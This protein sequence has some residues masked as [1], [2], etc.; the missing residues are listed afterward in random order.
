MAKNEVVKNFYANSTWTAPAGVKFVVVTTKKYPRNLF[1]GGFIDPFG[2]A[3]ACGLN[4]NGQLGLGDVT[5][6]SSPVAVLGGFA[7]KKVINMPTGS[8]T[9]GMSTSGNLYAWGLN[10]SGQL[11]VGDVTPRSSPVAVLGSLSFI[12]VIVPQYNNG[13]DVFGLTQSGALYAWGSNTKGQLGLGDTTVRSSPVAVVGGFTFGYFAAIDANGN[14]SCYG[15]TKAGVAYAWGNNANGQLGVGDVTAR[16]SPVAVLGGLTFAKI[17][18][19]GANSCTALGLTTAGVLYAWGANSSGRGGI[20]NATPQSSP[21][22]VAGGLTFKDVWTNSFGSTFAVT[23]NG[24]LYAW[25]V[26]TNGQLGIGNTSN[27]SSPN[28]VLVIS[29]VVK[30]I[31]PN[32]VNTGSP[33]SI[34]ALTSDGDVYGWGGNQNGALGVGDTTVRS[35]PVAVSGGLKF[36]DI[37]GGNQ[38]GGGSDSTTF[39]VTQDG[40]VYAW[41][42]NTNG[43]LGVGDVSSRSSPVTVLGN[44]FADPNPSTKTQVFPVTPGSSYSINV[45]QY[46]ASFNGNVIGQQVDIVTLR[47]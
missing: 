20:G 15:I 24:V 28:A 1:A 10:S 35:S 44:R 23:P 46:N 13:S 9:Y 39:G 5:A 17:V 3:V 7:F 8:A 2:N 4:A 29:N 45:N 25:G 21:V 16:S 18:G 19:A 11:G 43:E 47:Y 14:S 40:S 6:R 41:G 26:N 27:K 30:M 31:T 32:E 33:R 22:A 38:N 42:A 36:V 12:D 37:F 34:I